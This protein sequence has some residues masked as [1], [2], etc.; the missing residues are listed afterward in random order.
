MD[1][2]LRDILST[3]DTMVP[4]S[5]PYGIKIQWLN[6]IQ[7]QLFRDFPLPE[8]MFTFSAFPDE[9]QI[10]SLP[11]DCPEDG[12][13]QVVVDGV[14]YDYI[15]QGMDAEMDQ[16]TFYSIVLGSL[17]LYPS[18]SQI[19]T[20]Y[21]YYKSRPL[22]LTVEDL[23]VVPN[24]P[25]DFI[26]LLIFGCASRVAKTSPETMNLAAVLDRDY[27]LLAD[28]ADRVLTKPRPRSTNIVRGWN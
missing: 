3:V 25:A 8:G 24:F 7:N 18:P 16:T 27:Q 15:P 26:E 2:T 11:S 6:H 22:Q 1:L 20:V 5:L 9:E 10:Y 4:N 12:I 14:P 19:V 28:K 21:V 13:K 23:D 17:I